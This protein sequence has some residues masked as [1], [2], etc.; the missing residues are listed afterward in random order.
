[1]E[2]K[3][4]AHEGDLEVTYNETDEL[5]DE[6]FQKLIDFFKKYNA[7]SG[8]SI[9]QNDDPLIYASE[10]LSDI[11]DDLICFKENWTDDPDEE[12]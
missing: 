6:V 11:C 12:N 2:K 4:L 3:I 10:L 8:D 7:F 1:M 9:M 5:K